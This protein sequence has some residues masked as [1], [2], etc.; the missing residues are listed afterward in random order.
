MIFNTFQEQVRLFLFNL[1]TRSH[2]EIEMAAVNMVVV[3][4]APA[5]DLL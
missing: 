5:I 3:V 4:D 2:L 1:L